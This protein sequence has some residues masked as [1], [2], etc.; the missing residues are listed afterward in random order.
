MEK[1]NFC[2]YS[3][4]TAIVLYLGVALFTSGKTVMECRALPKV[5][6]PLQCGFERSS[7]HMS[8]Y[9]V[10]LVAFLRA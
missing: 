9:L 4:C 2:A 3:Q 10:L 1:V 5:Q 6:L 7:R 8:G